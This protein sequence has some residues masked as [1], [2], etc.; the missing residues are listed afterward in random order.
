MEKKKKAWMEKRWDLWGYFGVA[1]GVKTIIIGIYVFH[2][3]IRWLHKCRWLYTIVINEILTLYRALGFL[4]AAVYVGTSLR[5]FSE[6]TLRGWINFENF[7]LGF[8]IE[9]YRKTK[10]DGFLGDWE[11]GFERNC[12][13]ILAKLFRG[14]NGDIHKVSM[15]N[16]S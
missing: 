8:F 7:K 13:E 2:E 6:R 10:Y 5:G 1:T 3:G 16:F 11:W 9:F 15:R 12:W 4:L 14:I